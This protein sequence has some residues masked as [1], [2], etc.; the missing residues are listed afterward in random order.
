MGEDEC[1]WKEEDRYGEKPIKGDHIYG[2]DSL[3]FH[4]GHFPQVSGTPFDRP[5][6]DI[7]RGLRRKEWRD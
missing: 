7:E 4:K 3:P 5:M 6:K 1:V 2:R